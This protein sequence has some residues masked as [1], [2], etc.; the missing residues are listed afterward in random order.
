MQITPKVKIECRWCLG[1]GYW[2]QGF[3]RVRKDPCPVCKGAKFDWV[4][5]HEVKPTDVVVK[6]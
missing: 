5:P 4:E 6:R 1:D 2:S 3:S